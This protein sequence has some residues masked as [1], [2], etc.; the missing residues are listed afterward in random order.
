M[1]FA[2]KRPRLRSGTMILVTVT[3]QFCLSSWSAD[4]ARCDDWP[5]WQHD[6]RRTGFSPAKIDIQKFGHDWSWQSPAPPQ[7]AWHGP[8]RWD[9]YAGIRGLP[10]M[11]S[12]DLVFHVTAADG[13][14]F[15]ASTVDDS[16]RCMEA[17]SGKVKWIFTADA[18]IRIAPTVADGR[19]YFGSDDGLARC[20]DA[21]SGKLLWQFRPLPAGEQR[22]LNNGRF[23]SRYPCRTGIVVDKG[24]AWFS[25]SLLPWDESYLCCVDALTG[26]SDGPGM[27]VRKLRSKTL[28]GS[29]ALSRDLILFPQGRVAPQAFARSDG[30][31]LGQLKKSGGGS[32]VVVSADSTILHGPATDSR[33]GG[34]AAS[35]PKTL[36]SVAGYGRANA[37]V[38]SDRAAYLLNDHELIASELGSKKELFRVPCKFPYALIGAGDVL[39]AGGDD[40]VA[41]FSMR[42]GSLLSTHK[43]H[44]RAYGLAV[45]DGRLFVS[46]DEGTIASFKSGLNSGT[47]PKPGERD[48]PPAEN[49]N[50]VASVKDNRLLGRW[51]FHRSEVVGASVRDRAGN[52]DIKVE[53]GVQIAQAGTRQAMEFD[54][55]N[56]TALIASN[57][58]LAKVPKRE[59]TVEAWVRVDQPMTWGGFIGAI[60]DNGDFERGWI[61]GF[62]ENRFSFALAGSEANGKLTYLT[63][64]NP[65]QNQNWHHVAGTYDGTTMSL[66]V[67]GRLEATSTDQKGNIRYP[68]LAYYEVGAYHD[69]DEYHRLQGAIHEIRVYDSVLSDDEIAR[70]HKSK[71]AGFPVPIETEEPTSGPWFRFTGLDEATVRWETAEA[72]PTLLELK[73]PRPW[74]E[75]TKY[76]DDSPRRRHEVRLK[77]LRRNRLYTYSIRSQF[78]ERTIQSP[79]YECDTFFNYGVYPKMMRDDP[80]TTDDEIVQS[81]LFIRDQLAADSGIA[82]VVGL[83]DGQLVR[84]LAA[85]SQFRIVCVDDD[86]GRVDRLRQKLIAESLYGKRVSI[87]HVVNID[88]L[89]FVGHFANLATSER[90]LDKLS[91]GLIS[92]SRRCLAPGRGTLVLGSSD[93]SNAADTTFQESLRKTVEE[94]GP[95][96][97]LSFDERGAWAVYQSKPLDG[98]GAWT[99]LYANSD[100][101]AFGGESLAGAKSTDD[102]EIQWLGR[103]GPR[104]QA[105]RSGRKPSPLAASGRLFMQ[106]LNRII[107]LD[108]FNG[109][110][111]WSLEI[112]GFERFNVPR[113]CG[114][115]C[116]DFSHVY[117]AVQGELWKIDAETGNVLAQL[118]VEQPDDRDGE[119]HWGFIAEEN[120]RLIGSAVKSGSSW[121]GYWGKQ[122][123]YD[124]RS[125]PE[126]FKICSDSLFS[127]SSDDGTPLWSRTKG[128]ILNSTIT[129][130][131]GV[132]YF[133]ECRN[134]EIVNAPERR[135]G[136][137]G[138]WKNQF[139]VALDSNTGSVRWEKPIDTEDGTVV[140]YLA[141]S[142]DKL[143]TVASNEKKFH[144]DAFSHDD[145]KHIW[146]RSTGWFE[147]KGDHGKAMSRPAIVGDK[148]FLRPNVLSLTDGS[149]LDLKMPGGGCGT[150]ACTTNALFFR[151]GNVTVWDNELGKTTAWPRLRPGCWVSTIP[152]NGM[153]LAPEGGGGCSCG[154]WMETSIGFMPVG[155]RKRTPEKP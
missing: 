56:R 73:S 19:V 44:G 150:Y 49:T 126:T 114:N 147:D 36:E 155:H 77:E 119:F 152:A 3:A 29:P 28:E 41:V 134:P 78:V 4:S 137:P 132:V 129:I 9:A 110:I 89:P 100:N 154:S 113:D 5:T 96:T 47:D 101:S 66:F 12:Y 151:S 70:H 68:P 115:W 64:K 97:K 111:L 59:I 52:G 37:L 30:R 153:L 39:F 35:N 55:Q 61:L 94:A 125:G 71:A 22:F 104:Y 116:A 31:D 11:R 106:G 43:V 13:R 17:D 60:Q 18:P 83:S 98:A 53:G 38:V 99:H 103:P 93:S 148:V 46:T 2:S 123:W 144:V 87:H 127:R 102:L 92:E 48:D 128:V 63:A 45:S 27:Y 149:P 15:F 21:S 54:D 131:D 85:R 141:H 33:K 80:D 121:D 143:M 81:A 72:T 139:M 95:G 7:P 120:G 40:S 86:I 146:N 32:I 74:D 82:L 135:I 24:K 75:V 58:R 145:G 14:V 34:V 65:F 107:A 25:C 1:P 105:D 50:P 67:D 23:I 76:E 88:R 10:S 117:A 8:A 62:R 79:S 69:K 140:F 142:G 26:K 138:L 16:V 51:V 130:S 91:S 20:L 108:G 90:T 118:K 57:Y 84:E 136:S 122:G 124:A 133:I 6:Q 112:P 42:D 109:S